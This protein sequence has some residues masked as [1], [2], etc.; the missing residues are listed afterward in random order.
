MLSQDH[1]AAYQHDGVVRI[2]NA[3]S[4]EWL[5]EVRSSIE[6]GRANPGPMYLDYSKDTSPG[7]YCTD[8]W[9]WRENTHMKNF[10]FNSP[11][12]ELAGEV[13]E[14]NSV[15]LV[16]D[17]WLVREAGAV[18]KAPWHHDNP[19]FDVSGEWCVLWMG[20]EPVRQ[21]EGVVFLKGS[22]KWGRKFM[23]LSF[24]GTGQKAALQEPYEPTPDFT[25]NLADYDVLEFDLDPGDCLI[26][27]SHTLHGAPNPVPPERTVNRLTMRFAHGNAAFE[28]RGSWT[29]AQTEYWQAH[30]MKEGEPIVGDLLPLVW[31]R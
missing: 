23:P 1:I 3:F 29:D 24:A 25:E 8:M 28:K 9:I 27:D 4:Q 20:L 22:Y 13:M 26:F 31:S 2:K 10:I 30:G 11:A 12:A 17:N 7:T 15:A 19:Y 16:T 21:G 14:A 5:D 6:F 18:N